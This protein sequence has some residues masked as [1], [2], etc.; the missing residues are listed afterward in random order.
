[1]SSISTWLVDSPLLGVTLS[2]ITAVL[3][4]LGCYAVLRRLL[5]SHTGPDSE[6][7]AS[8][9]IARLG[10]LHALILALMFA[11]EMDDYLA[12]SRVVTHE[13]SAISD[14]YNDI[15]EYDRE[16]PGATA[17]ISA[18]IVEYVEA[19]LREERTT[20]SEA[21]LSRRTWADY[22]RIDRALRDLEPVSEYQRDLSAQ[23][24]SDWDAVSEFR[25]QYEL[26]AEHKVPGFFWL[27]ALSGFFAVVIPF[28]VYSPNPANL[29]TISIFAAFNGI[30]LYIILAIANPFTG[31]GAIGSTALEDLLVIMRSG[32]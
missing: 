5:S 22:E 19:V 27:L 12:V 8:N 2:V 11:Q 6:L 17:A 10:T 7:F 30:V 21:G 24:L 14:V 25:E 13:A 4:A 3:F 28:Y 31:P 16:N 9:I 23:M 29:L 20:L 32:P 15:R 18:M 1:M 26:A